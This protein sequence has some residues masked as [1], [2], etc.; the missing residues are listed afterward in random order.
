MNV[1]DVERAKQYALER[2]ARD[3]SPKLFYHS[4]S[5]TWNDVAP[6]VERLAALESV[7]GE[8]LLLLRTAAYYHDIGFVERRDDHESTGV[9][10]ASVV[11]PGFGYS[12]DQIASIADM[13][14]ATR[15]PQSPHNLL[16]QLLADADLDA[17][18]RED[19]MARNQALRAEM[20]AFGLPSTDRQWYADQLQFLKNHRYW[21]VAARALRDPQKQLNIK[22]LRDLI[23]ASDLR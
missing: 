23:E 5:H 11:L 20:A 8:A 7:D 15:L 6:A 4:L 14:M 12:P 22:L 17:L 1:P 13:I 16:E 18:G 3:L 19:F 21:T 2:L 10:I 9:R